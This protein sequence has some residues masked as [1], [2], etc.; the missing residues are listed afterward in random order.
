MQQDTQRRVCK[1][2]HGALL[3]KS[4]T[5]GDGAARF[6]LACEGAMRNVLISSL[7]LVSCGV[8]VTHVS[9]AAACGGCFHGAVEATPSVVTAHR[10]ALSISPTRTVLWDQVEYSGNPS[11]FAWVL[12]VGAG[13]YIEESHDAWFEALEAVT[14]TRVMSDVVNCAN[15]TTVRQQEQSGGCGAPATMAEDGYAPGTNDAAKSQG[16]GADVTVEHQGTVG[17]YETV[18]LKS[19]DPTAL[20]TWLVSNGYAIPSDIEPV[21]DAYVAEGAE[22]I[23]LRLKPGT[24]V[25]Q[26]TPVRVVTPG[27]SPVLPLRMVAAGTGPQVSIVLY[28]IS[29]GRF[30][31]QNFE[32]ARI[33]YGSL[34][35]DWLTS[36]S[37]Y[38]ETRTAALAGGAWLT[39]FARRGAM[40]TQ[41][42][43]PDSSVAQYAV[44]TTGQSYQSLGDLYFAQAAADDGE[45]ATCVGASA[46]AAPGLVVETCDVGGCSDEVDAALLEC[47]LWTDLSAALIGMHP[48]D[49]WVTRLESELPRARL[50]DDLVLQAATA[51]ATVENW[52]VATKNQNPPCDTSASNASPQASDVESDDSGCVLGC[53]TRRPVLSNVTFLGVAAIAA[54]SFFRR[55]SRKSR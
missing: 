22:F 43:T 19:D 49:V 20:R 53:S 11:E 15:G 52:H 23:A 36:R 35:W 50:A 25:Q 47:G 16:R 18:T 32:E 31:T 9:D 3:A 28:V 1:G 2:G 30:T 38:A 44:A 54:L 12:P 51:Q 6:D 55:R 42:T 17:P 27:A 4:P 13:A 33:D 39:S 40:T 46:L 48:R 37:N 21:L 7:I 26:M 8:L 45:P 24:G 14:A 34:S 5:G 29:E 10:M 41:I